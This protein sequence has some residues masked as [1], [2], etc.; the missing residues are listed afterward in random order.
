MK[1]WHLGGP[2]AVGRPQHSKTSAKSEP[3]KPKL[4]Q[5][6]FATSGLFG[7]LIVLVG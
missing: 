7:S 5:E 2:I 4:A 3:N 6:I 1:Q